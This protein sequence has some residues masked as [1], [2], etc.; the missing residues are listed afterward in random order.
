MSDSRGTSGQM[1][2][3]DQTATVTWKDGMQFDGTTVQLH[4]GVEARTEQ[5][6]LTAPLVEIELSQHVSLSKPPKDR[7]IDVQ[8]VRLRGQVTLEN[9][10][11]LEGELT[12]IDE[13]MVRDLTIDQQTGNLTAEGPGWMKTVRKGTDLGPAQFA[14][15]AFGSPARPAE[16]ARQSGD[17]MTYLR[18]TFQT[19]LTGNIQQRHV[20]LH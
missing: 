3:S 18:V 15:P 14:G 11:E 1:P 2:R 4:G 17:E 9:R 5:Q 10:T 6:R 20:E 13:M 19:G 16:P 12:S 8:Q 7:A